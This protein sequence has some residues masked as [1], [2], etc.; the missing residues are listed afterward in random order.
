[1]FGIVISLVHFDRGLF[2]YSNFNFSYIDDKDE[3]DLIV[4]SSHS[5]LLTI[6]NKDI[7]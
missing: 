5:N 3:T 2:Y 6:P 1:M 7:Q 4:R